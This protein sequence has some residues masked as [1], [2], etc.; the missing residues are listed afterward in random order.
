[1]TKKLTLAAALICCA[2]ALVAVNAQEKEKEKEPVWALKFQD[3]AVTDVFKG[4]PAQPVLSTRAERMFRTVL[5]GA[6][7][8][9]P[10]FAGHYTVAV[11]GCG[12]GCASL[13]VVDAISGRV[14]GAPFRYIS[15]PM[16]V[17][18]G[19]NY[20]GPVYQLNSKLLIADGCVEDTTVMICGTYYYE[21]TANN[22]KLLRFGPQLK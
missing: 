10:N 1:M 18:Y 17:E 8:K 12:S 13:A 22:F 21:W 16:P 19:H 3:F 20:Q 6:A 15:M 11:W 5:R 2:C 7:A 4:K 14:Y 9:G